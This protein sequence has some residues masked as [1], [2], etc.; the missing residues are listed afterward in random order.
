MNGIEI[1]MFI[2]GVWMQFVLE[3][4]GAGGAIWG[5]SEVW[6]MRGDTN[7][8]GHAAA[9]DMRWGANIVFCLG[10][11]RFLFRYGPANSIQQAIVDPQN[12]IVDY[13]RGR[14]AQP[15]SE[16]GYSDQGMIALEVPVFIVG[17][18]L[19]WVLEVLGAGGATWGMSEVWHLR[20][21]TVSG[22]TPHAAN[23]DFR[24]VANVT[25]CIG[26]IRMLQKYCPPHDVHKA[27][28][29][30]QDW[31]KDLGR[32]KGQP[33]GGSIQ[34]GGDPDGNINL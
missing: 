25:F 23:T 20:G 8:R 30:P 11:I 13:G 16:Q 17:V 5:M 6:H 31:I 10:L 15:K 29:S 34:A 28:L 12:W 21:G 1:F 32:G 26:A 18:F 27:M 4:L 24:W 14:R 3:V 9:T 7:S 19:Q 22:K 2:V 33:Q